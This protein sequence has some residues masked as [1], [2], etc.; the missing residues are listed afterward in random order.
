MVKRVRFTVIYAVLLLSALS[1]FGQPTGTS[2]DVQRKVCYKTSTVK[3]FAVPCGVE[4]DSLS[5]LDWVY[6]WK[7]PPL[8]RFSKF[9]IKNYWL[10]ITTTFPQMPRY[11]RDYEYQMGQSVTDKWGIRL[12]YH[13]GEEYY[14]LEN[15]VEDET[16]AVSATDIENYGFYN[17]FFNVSVNEVYEQFQMLGIPVYKW[18]QKL[19]AVRTTLNEG[20]TVEKRVEREID[21]DKLYFETRTFENNIHLFTERTEYQKT[22]NWIIPAEKKRVHYSELP[23]ETRYQ[24]TETE[25]YL[26]YQVTGENNNELVNWQIPFAITHIA[27]EPAQ[28]TIEVHFSILVEGKITTEIK[29]AANYEMLN[30]EDTLSGNKMIIDIMS[31]DTGS[32]VLYCHYNNETAKAKFTKKGMEQYQNPVPAVLSM[33]VVP[34]PAKDNITLVFPVAINAEMAIKITDMTGVVHFQANKYIADNTFSIDVQFLPAGM[35]YISCINNDGTAYTHFLK[36]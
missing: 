11:E 9:S 36:Q 2:A 13:N 34:N 23:S 10:T 29:N 19:L 33:Q 4:V 26:S 31:L 7:K 24:I 25:T 15:E 5:Q 16:F 17:G 18:G 1:A 14:N 6:L 35:Y 20:D 21:F 30:L 12:Y 3:C 22:D 8:I 32:Y 27:P 28:D